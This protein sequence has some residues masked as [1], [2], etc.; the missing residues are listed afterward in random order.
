M[1]ELTTKQIIL[2]IV[3]IIS[4][5]E[6]LIM[7]CVTA[8]EYEM[9]LYS[10]ALLDTVMLVVLSVPAI[11]FWV[12]KPFVEAREEALGE[13]RR[14][15]FTDPLTHLANRRLIATHLGKAIA[16]SVRHKDYGAVLLIDLD[17]FKPVNDTYGHEAGDTILVEFAERLRSAVRSE[18]VV[19]RLGGDEFVVLVHRLGADK[20]LANDKAMKLV[21]KLIDVVNR[22]F[23]FDGKTLQVGAS[24]GIRLLGLEQM[25]T[26]TA[27]READMAMYRAKQTGKGRAVIFEG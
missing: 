21:G 26:E 1:K 15:A 7:L 18:D 4:A 6:L 2:R 17:G 19:G 14:L 24:I 27:I 12:I 11:Y 9:D 13:I 25:D 10:R 8:I 23:V 5:I 20:Q 22:P 3:L 16:G